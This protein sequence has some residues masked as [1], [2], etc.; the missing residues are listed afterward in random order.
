VQYREALRH[1]PEF[2]RAYSGL[3]ASLLRL[4]RREEAQKNLDEA[5]RR[6]DRM[7]EREKLRTLGFY[8]AITRNYDKAIET[9]E[10]LVAKFPS[11][12]A[13]YSNLAI[14]YFNLLNFAKALE[15]GQK[16]VEIY[17][18]EY[19]Y[20]NNYALFAMYAGDF[21]TAATTAQTLI[22]EDPRIDLAYLPLAISAL[23]SGDTAGARRVFEQA[24][25]AGEAG[26]SVSA[27]G[28]AD[29]AMFEGRNAE[30]I[31][32]LPR[33]VLS[34][35][36]QGNSIGA[37]AKLV[38]LAE[39]HAALQDAKAR[40][41]AIARLRKLSDQDS[42]LVPVA[43]LAVA[44]GRVGEARAIAA[45]LAT[46]LPAQSRA[47]GKLIEAEIAMAGR[48]Y[49]TAIDELKTAQKLADLWLVRY[50]LGLAYFQR[51][52]YPEATSELQKCR[53]RRGE[54]TAAFLDDLPTFRYYA[55]LPYWL[56]RAREM[57]KLDARPQYQEFLRIREAATGDPLVDDARKRLGAT[58]G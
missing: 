36:A 52:D 46:R 8:F 57:Q 42:V 17:P 48:Q 41:A 33:A 27:L 44:A 12:T 38:A 24:A 54:A 2:G 23:S 49:L 55:T 21:A 14:S 58:S 22:Q 4:G 6:T 20:R 25:G 43:R 19:K 10:E 31:A 40:D 5:L 15:Y 26:A 45:E 53:D 9:Y 7:T 39:A 37:A 32:L 3:A 47:Y 1:D 28:L 51:G 35:E 16:A 18:K 50:A 29:V 30:A 13:G 34:D 11:D 56:G